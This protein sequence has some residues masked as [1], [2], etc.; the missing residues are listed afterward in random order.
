M[1]R[2]D[3]PLVTMTVATVVAA[4][5]ATA[6]TVSVADGS[7]PAYTPVLPTDAQLLPRQPADAYAPGRSD[8]GVMGRG[9]DGPGAVSRIVVEADRNGVPADGQ[10]AVEFV[11]RLFD[12]DGKP[13]A[14]GFATIEHSAGR[15]LLPGARTDELGPRGRDADRAVPGVQLPIIDGVARFKLLAPA[16]A[17][18]V[19]VRVT[20]GG[21]QASGLVTFVP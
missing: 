13:V 16:E 7:P 15:I 10:S 12:A 8:D 3:L 11:V 14:S 17:Q 20:A 2:R 18:D 4:I 1:A 9:A 21:R 19:R 5:L 6:S